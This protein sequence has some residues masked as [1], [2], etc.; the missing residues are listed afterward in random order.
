MAL[1]FK[2]KPTST[3]EFYMNI[4]EVVP[5]DFEKILR[6]VSMGELHPSTSTPEDLPY[7]FRFVDLP[8]MQEVPR[9]NWDQILTFFH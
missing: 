5:Q 8:A 1:E 6:L 2:Y 3:N 7:I 4:P 9:F